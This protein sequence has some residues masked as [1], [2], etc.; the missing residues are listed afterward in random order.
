MIDLRMKRAQMIDQAQKLYSDFP[1]DKMTATV[2]REFSK[3]MDSIDEIDAQVRYYDLQDRINNAAIENGSFMIQPRNGLRT[4]AAKRTLADAF[5]M[6][7]RGERKKIDSTFFDELGDRNGLR[8]MRTEYSSDNVVSTQYAQVFLE[9]VKDD[10][11]LSLIPTE[12]VSE[13]YY[14]IPVVTRENSPTAEGKANADAVS[15]TDTNFTSISMTPKNSYVLNRYHKDLIRDAGIRAK[16]AIWESSKQA[17][18]K[19][20]V[21]GILYGDSN[22]S[23]EFN[24]FDNVSGKT[25]YDTSGGSILD[26]SLITRGAKALNDRFVDHSEMIAIMSPNTHNKYSDL[27]ELTSSGAYLMPPPQIGMI[28]M[29]S[30]AQ[31]KT[32]YSSD[33]TR[34]YMFRPESTLLA[35]FGNFEIELNERFAEYDHAAYMLV[36]RSD[37]AFRDPEHLFIA[38][39]LPTA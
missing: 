22:N 6:L 37:F 17:I 25:V 28:P 21:Q 33:K 9:L 16:D 7:A 4:M 30:N 18:A 12:T 36:F 27:R 1:A 5:G 23:G 2:S 35:L 11:F 32:D 8:E 34:L 20:L 31:V 3:L 38:T 19:R 26:Y 29:I 10:R 13:S 14:K 15:G 39:N 24:G